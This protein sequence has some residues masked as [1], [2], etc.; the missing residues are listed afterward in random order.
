MVF[1]SRGTF[2]LDQKCKCLA[3]A[4]YFYFRWS[5]FFIGW[6][7]LLDMLCPWGVLVSPDILENVTLARLL[8]TVSE[9]LIHSYCG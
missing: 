5:R 3:A 4:V 7:G 9:I 6:L 1:I 8:R 2:V